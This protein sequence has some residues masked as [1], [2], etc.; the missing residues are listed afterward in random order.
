MTA[1]AG[2]ALGGLVLAASCSSESQR[3]CLDPPESESGLRSPV[4]VVVEPNPVEGGSEATLSV[5]AEGAPADS[6][7]GA[8]AEW[9]CW[10]GSAWVS[11][12]QIVRGFD[13]VDPQAIEVEPGATTTIPAIEFPLPNSFP[14]LIPG[15][16]AGT[17]R[18]SD[19]IVVA[20]ADDVVGFVLV[21]VR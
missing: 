11:T 19:Q 1:R 18:I 3:P 21:D 2:L 8:G 15:V 13:S 20:G 4:Q 7:T 16:S 10:S 9:Q 17:Y 12:H 14:I 6:G 5:L